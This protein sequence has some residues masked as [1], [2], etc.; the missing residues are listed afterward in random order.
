MRPA[1]RP[2]AH[3]R[4]TTRVACA[5][6]AATSLVATWIAAPSASAAPKTT[7]T[8]SL[9]T[10]PIA[11]QDYTMSLFVNE[12][13]G[14]AT[15]SLTVIFSRTAGTKRHPVQT[16]SYS[17]TLPASEFG[18][19]DKLTDVSVDTGSSMAKQGA[20]TMTLKHLG[21]K[22]TSTTPCVTT[23]S[24]TG[25]LSGLFKLVADTTYFHTVKKQEL[26]ASLTESTAKNG[27]GGGSSSQCSAGTTLVASNTR[28]GMF[29]N[30]SRTPSENGPPTVSEVVSY[31]QG[32]TG[33]MPATV[34]HSIQVSGAT[35]KALVPS[36]DLTTASLNGSPGKPFLTG[37]VAYTGHPPTAGACS[38]D[39]NTSTS[40][41]TVSG[42][43]VAH[44]DSVGNQG[45]T[46]GKKVLATL[47]Q[48]A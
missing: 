47:T 5:A 1:P 39:L 46:G 31:V 48:V 11:V 37:G 38:K 24:R 22:Q 27:C 33:T 7:T 9:S 6:V 19:N 32:G 23:V 30:A 16:H 4:V 29:L 28:R 41:G 45:F 12:T 26:P 20:I 44:F 34:S 2:L 25:T 21:D 42:K 18:V 36:T 13:E 10:V 40:T 35:K 43:L 17:F 14:A 15:L 3:A 8:F